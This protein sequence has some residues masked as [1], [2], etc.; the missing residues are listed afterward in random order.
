MVFLLPFGRV[1][2]DMP[3]VKDRYF[4][5]PASTVPLWRYIDLAKFVALVTSQALWFSNANALVE[6][7]PYEGFFPP[8]A[9][10][11]LV[12]GA[13]GGGER[14]I[15]P[16]LERDAM[17]LFANP[18]RLVHTRGRFSMS[19][20]HAGSESA[21]MWRS[22]GKHDSAMAIVSNVPKMQAAFARTPQ[23]IKCGTVRYIEFTSNSYFD[24]FR[25]LPHLVLLKRQ[26]FASENEVRLVCT[27]SSEGNP[28][29]I[30]ISCSLNELIHSI[31]ISPTA[32][33]WAERA[34][35]DLCSL[36]ALT[37][38]IVRSKLLSPPELMEQIH[39]RNN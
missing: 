8:S 10:D 23:D 25:A 14:V 3:I 4:I 35:T 17:D 5:E 26:A 2:G 22:Y 21:A 12:P 13:P 32:P 36:V 18:H 29:G 16:E 1:G 11:F 37:P 30:S 9:R 19:C 24:N 38:P 39:P 33:N 7:D 6:E 15:G 34:V 31:V 27:G 28:K 20:W